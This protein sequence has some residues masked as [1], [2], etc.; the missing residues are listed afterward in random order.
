MDSHCRCKNVNEAI[1]KELEMEELEGEANFKGK[2]TEGI[3][4]FSMSP[5]AVARYLLK[6]KL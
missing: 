4:K 6:T 1:D 5:I 3:A 2:R